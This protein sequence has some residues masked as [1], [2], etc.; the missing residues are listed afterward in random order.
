MQVKK[1]LS[2]AAL[3]ATMAEC[4]GQI[5]DPRQQG[6]VGHCL[7]DVLMSG[8]AMMFFQDP[9]L[10]AFQKRLQESAQQNNLSKVF[11]VT[12]IP[13]D[14]QMRDVIDMLPTVALD[15]IFPDFLNRLQ[16]GRQL[17]QYRFLNDK[18]LIPIDGTE[19][20]SSEKISCPYCLETKPAKGSMRY[21]H[22]ILQ[23][24]IVHPDMRQVIPLFPEPIQN[25]D[26]YTK[27]DCETNAGK[28][29]VE[30]IR[31]AHPKLAI[32]ITGDDLYSKQPFIDALKA[33]GMSYILV[34]KPTDHKILFEWV[35]EII[36]MAEAE[37]L[38]LTDNKGKRHKYQWI[39]GVPLNGSRNADH[40][41]FFQYSIIDKKGKTTYRN[42]W[43][44]DLV[45]SRENIQQLVKGGRARWKIENETFNT[46]KNQG[47]HIEH[48]YGHG[49]Q[50]LSMNFFVLNLLA[51]FVHQIL[52]LCELS[53]Q[54]CR[55]KFS[56]RKE[57]WNQLRC[58]FRIILFRDLNHLLDYLFNPPM[59]RAP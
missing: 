6:K 45:V 9:S 37:H 55:T 7:H 57:F 21:H 51:F 35:D 14:T 26:G 47:Y 59:V 32:I 58:T 31:K 22:Q 48:N 29:I 28:R 53:Y 5:Q 50:Y 16:R 34:A 41:N 1:H 13:K 24:V 25:S 8:F 43:V 40:V 18:Y 11:G 12:T 46:L 15:N 36:G 38:E 23:A 30:K 27:Q 54:L 33:N 10:L 4:F 2:F 39:N 56:S 44:T 3:L 42:S 49:K 17:D 19:Y 52:E 20:F